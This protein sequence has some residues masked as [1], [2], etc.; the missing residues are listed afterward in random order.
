M[1]DL[2]LQ[3]LLRIEDSSEL[4]LFR[5]EETDIPWWPAIRAV[6]LRLIMSDL[7][8]KESII[9]QRNGGSKSRA[10]KYLARSIAHNAATR[11]RNVRAEL[12]FMTDS[13]G[14]R[15]V[16]GEWFNRLNGYFTARYPNS[17]I[18]LE[19]HYNWEWQFPRRSGPVLLHAGDRVG[20]A[21][22]AKILPINISL[23]QRAEQMLDLLHARSFA[24]LGWTPPPAQRQLLVRM[25]TQKASILRYQYRHYRALLKKISPRL[26]FVNAGAYGPF[27]AL[28]VAAK[29]LGIVTA[30][31]QHGAIS[32]GHDAYNVAPRLA[33]D[34]IYAKCLPDYFLSYGKWWTDQI[35]LPFSRISIGNPHRD[36]QIEAA[37]NAA[38][39]PRAGAAPIILILGDG[40]DTQIYINL[41]QA[42]TVAMSGRYQVLF[43][44]HPME[45]E[46]VRRK[47]Q[48]AVQM[49]CNA[50]IYASLLQAEVVISE[51]STG[52][53]EAIG[54]S[55]RIFMW[56]TKK[57][58]FVYPH[59]PF[60][61]FSNKD[62]LIHLIDSGNTGGLSQDQIRTIWAPDWKTNFDSFV[63]LHQNRPA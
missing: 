2:S 9:K 58:Q 42:L 25:L 4:M 30:E 47:F 28:L 35:N 54:L 46:E 37:T 7:L 1:N 23:Q 63:R 31:V 44:P 13:V 12:C 16:N 32:A 43:R 56:N 62:D 20:Q 61:T 38:Q 29:S 27:A 55:K 53:F 48:G 10:I 50:D 3:D 49:D 26:L 24:E 17:S 19:D 59:P 11:L 22:L 14:N 21:L 40:I 51:I 60:A 39:S 15:Q 41:A 8:Y 6:Y 45:R 18:I 57:S 34:P 33:A 52:L 36:A 5:C